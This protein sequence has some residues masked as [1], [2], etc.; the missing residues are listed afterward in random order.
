MTLPSECEKPRANAR[1]RYQVM[2]GTPKRL[3][4][5]S[6][7]AATQECGRRR[8]PRK[9]ATISGG[10]NNVLDQDPPECLSCSLNGYDA[11]LYDLP[12]QFGYVE[13]SVGF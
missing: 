11:S 6:T 4:G 12:G 2:H 10:I 5:D 7:T 1:G 13:A 3:Q 9:P 8:P